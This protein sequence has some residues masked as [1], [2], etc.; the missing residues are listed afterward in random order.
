M[1]SF[2]INVQ[3]D[4]RKNLRICRTQINSMTEEL[5]KEFM[6]KDE[7]EPLIS[8]SKDLVIADDVSHLTYF[9]ALLVMIE[10]ETI[11]IGKKYN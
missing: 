9:N 4:I 10:K 2:N 5:L 3:N 8:N 11:K 7:Y 1:E 6:S